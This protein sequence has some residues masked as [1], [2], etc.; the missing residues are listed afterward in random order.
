MIYRN[1]FDTKRLNFLFLSEN[2]G[3]ST[4]IQFTTPFSTG[5]NTLVGAP[6]MSFFK[7]DSE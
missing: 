6:T 7:G 2:I 5:Q 1:F 4:K 3:E